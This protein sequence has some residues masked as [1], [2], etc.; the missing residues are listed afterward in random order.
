MKG[1]AYHLFETPIGTCGVAWSQTGAVIRL[2]LPESTPKVTEQ[3]IARSSC[4]RKAG[5]PPPAIAALV[6]KIKKHLA[7]KLQDF[8][9]VPLDLSEFA[10]FDRQVY[11]TAKQIPPG[12]TSTYGDLAKAVANSSEG[13]GLCPDVRVGARAVGQAMARNPVPLIIPCHRVLPANGRLGGFSAHGEQQ[14]KARLL[15]IE[16]AKFPGILAFPP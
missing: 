12:E 4:G 14:T 5:T 15:S 10:E 11:E 9:D 16:R 13:R 1:T 6:G 7:G 8:R 2:Q 3:R